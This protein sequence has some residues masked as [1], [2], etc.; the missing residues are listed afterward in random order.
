MLDIGG[1]GNQKIA[2]KDHSEIEFLSLEEYTT[3][4][5]KIISKMS[6]GFNRTFL[7]SDDI[8]SY[9]ANAIMMADWRWDSEYNSKEGRKKSQYAY[10]NQCAIWAIKTFVSK[11]MYKNNCFS[12]EDNISESDERNNLNFYPDEKQ[13]DPSIIIEIND[14]YLQIKQDVDDLLN[15]GILTDKQKEYVSLYYLEGLTLEKIGHKF[16]ITREAVR[17]NINK[18]LEK[19]RYFISNDKS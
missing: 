17:Q 12:L 3:M 9:V 15:S 4:A 8:I 2:Y 14:A 16:G 18:S 7:N 1:I 19:I 11:K 13:E 5:K 10:R 6:A